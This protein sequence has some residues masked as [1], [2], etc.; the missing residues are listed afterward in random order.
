MNLKE[1]GGFS[2][3]VYLAKDRDKSGSLVDRQETSGSVK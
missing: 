1:R 2:Y 3:L